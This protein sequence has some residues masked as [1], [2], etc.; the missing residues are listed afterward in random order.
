MLQI[1]QV[2][3][4]DYENANLSLLFDSGSDRSCISESCA[5]KL[6]LKTI[7]KETNCAALFGQGK[8]NATRLKNKCNVKLLSTTFECEEM[9]VSETPTICSRIQRPKLPQDID[10]YLKDNGL[11]LATRALVDSDSRLRIEIL[12]G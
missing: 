8:P 11:K 6:G 2:P 9:I 1:A 10:P 7:G 5:K 12:V 4:C 3:V